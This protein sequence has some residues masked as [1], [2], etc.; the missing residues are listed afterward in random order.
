M[1]MNFLRPGEKGV[2]RRVKGAA[3]TKRFLANLGFVDGTEVSVVSK[4]GGNLI[5]IIRDSRV[6]INHEM[7]KCILV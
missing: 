1:P 2:I 4:L 5:V 7:A 3:D 6:A